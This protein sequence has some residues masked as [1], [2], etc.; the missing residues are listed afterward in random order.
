MEESQILKLFLVIGVFALLLNIY[1]ISII[2]GLSVKMFTDFVVPALC[3]QD[4]GT[5]YLSTPTDSE[6]CD[7]ILDNSMDSEA[8]MSLCEESYAGQ[9]EKYDSCMQL[10]DFYEMRVEDC[11]TYTFS[12]G[13][14]KT[15]SVV[16]A[17]VEEC[18]SVLAD[19]HTVQESPTGLLVMQELFQ[20]IKGH[21]TRG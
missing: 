9:D 17:E 1:S 8:M 21:K 11:V 2:D 6:F 13:R 16:P 18:C 15:V 20:G 14:N 19:A 5:Y 3:Q 12:L 10:V 4:N 7:K